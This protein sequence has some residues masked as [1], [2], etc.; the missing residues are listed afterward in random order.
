[1]EGLGAGNY[2]RLSVGQ[3]KIIA[4]A[5]TER[6][7]CPVRIQSQQFLF[8]LLPHIRIRLHSYDPV[9]SPAPN[10][11]GQACAA[12]HI[13]NKLRRFTPVKGKQLRHFLRCRGPVGVVQLLK[14]QKTVYVALMIDLLLHGYTPFVNSPDPAARWLRHRLWGRTASYPGR[15]PQ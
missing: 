15:F 11:G 3:P 6:K 5:G 4:V 13:H 9:G 1:M 7:H 14:P 12:A 10:E 2:I 8:C